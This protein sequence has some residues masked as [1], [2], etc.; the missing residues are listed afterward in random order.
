MLCRIHAQRKSRACALKLHAY[1]LTTFFRHVRIRGAKHQQKLASNIG[2]S[3]Q[4]TR[5]S[6]TSKL[7]VVNASPVKTGCRKYIR[8]ERCPECQMPADAE[9]AGTKLSFFNSSMPTQIVERRSAVRIKLND[10][11]LSRACQST[12]PAFIIKRNHC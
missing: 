7:P 10:R 9:S 12:I 6:V 11:C 4:R 8:L 3:L 2:S 5:I 1:L